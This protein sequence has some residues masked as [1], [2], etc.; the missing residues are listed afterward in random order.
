MDASS[1][2]VREPWVSLLAQG[3]K[4]WELR[5]SATH[6]RGRVALAASGTSCI[7][8]GATLVDCVGPLSDA[9]VDAE[10]LR[11]CIPAGSMPRRYARTFAW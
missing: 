7:V 8:A 10:R 11:H 4:T 5:G 6:K 9:A 3:L 1:A 2:A